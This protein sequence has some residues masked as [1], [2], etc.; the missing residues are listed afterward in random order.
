MSETNDKTVLFLCT[1]N[2]YRSRFAEGLFNHLTGIK[3]LAWRARSRGLHIDKSQTLNIGPI[4]PITLEA[5][6]H[7]SIPIPEPIPNPGQVTLDDLAS[8]DLVVALKE[9][10]HRALVRLNFPDW[11]NRVAYWHVHDLDKAPPQKA[12]ADIDR[13]VRA[14][15]DRLAAGGG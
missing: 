14:L 4:S 11:E 10:E 9:E 15:I 5:F 2:Y 8:A 13:L 6:K 7:H 12:L 1:G 3:G